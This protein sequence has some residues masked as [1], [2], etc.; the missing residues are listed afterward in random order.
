[1]NTGSYRAELKR[2][3]KWAPLLSPREAAVADR[4][5]GGLPDKLI[6]SDLGI[7]VHTVREYFR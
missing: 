4:I 2:I 1:M 5:L 7:S 6:A 3:P